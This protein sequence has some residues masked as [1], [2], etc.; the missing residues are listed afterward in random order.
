MNDEGAQRIQ[1]RHSIFIETV[2][3][4]HLEGASVLNGVLSDAQHAVVV[5][6]KVPVRIEYQRMQDNK[7]IVA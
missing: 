6:A 3:I 1:C 5:R 7:S 2:C 4:S